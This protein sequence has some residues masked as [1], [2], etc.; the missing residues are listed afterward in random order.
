MRVRSGP[1]L[2]SLLLTV[3]LAATILLTR[4]PTPIAT[5]SEVGATSEAERAPATANPA[6]E[7]GTVVPSP[8]DNPGL[9]ADCTTLLALEDTLTG[10]ATLNW[11]A[12]TAI[13][14]WDGITLAGTPQRVTKLQ[15][16][17]KGLDGSIPPG[18][19]DLE[20]LE[21]LFLIGNRLTGTIPPA[22]GALAELE[23]L[24]LHRN[25]LTGPIPPELGAL[26]SLRW[27]GLHTNQLTGPIPVELASLPVLQDLWLNSNQLTGPIPAGLVDRSLRVL[28]LTGNSGLTG[29]IPVGLK[30]IQTNDLATLGLSDCTTTTTYLLTTTAGAGGTTSPRPGTHRYLS[31]ASVTVTATPAPYHDLVSR[32]DD[33]SGTATTCTLTLDAAKTAS[34]TFQVQTYTLTVTATGGGSVTPSGTTTENGG[35]E[36]TLTATWDDATHTFTGWSGDCS[37][38]ETTCELLI[39]AAKTVTATFAAL[40]AD[41]CATATAADC[42]RAVYKGAPGDY[43]Q[44]QEIPADKLLTPGSDGRYQV[45]RGQQITVVTAAPLPT[46]YTRFYLQRRNLQDPSPVSAEQLIKP[47][48]TTYTFTVETTESR[49]N[50]ITYDLTAARPRPNP[51][52]GQKPE[53]GG[54]VV[55]TEFLVPTLRYNLL[56]TTG[57]ATAAGSYAFLQTAGDATSAIENFGYSAEEGVELRV[58]PSDASGISRAAFY[59]TVQ[60]GSSFDYR[61]NGLDCGFRFKVTSVAA[62]ASPRTFGIQAVRS[63]GGWCGDLVDDPGAAKDVHLVW[64]ARSGLPG[65]GGVPLLL[66]NELTGQGTYR[67]VDGQPY[68]IDVP[69][70]AMI[71]FGGT[72]IN[73]P[74]PDNPNQPRSTVVLKDTEGSSALHIDPETGREVKRVATSANIA[75]LFDQIMTSIRRVE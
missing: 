55:T 47:V 2:F 15:L 33:C 70:G 12:D 25:Q 64:H 41:R 7:N 16:S 8:A 5:A 74:E 11:D 66:R 43:A 48:G 72:R 59:D 28:Y 75:A 69:A 39:D 32:G 10:T 24:Y 62:T 17:Y 60:V 50:L 34:V 9:V 37:G 42:I 58:H 21:W 52:P 38:S 67:L 65:Q 49:P 23:I 53:L 68:V 29:C 22:L 30:S 45:E 27:L 36:L 14:S 35:T 56:D 19:S 46:G 6:C 73:E 1:F 3:G 57:G 13:A 51:R 44:V 40:P 4:E 61:T 71:I 20:E 31:G 54:V 63:Y 26:S 18:L